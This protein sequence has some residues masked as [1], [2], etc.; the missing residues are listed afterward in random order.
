MD[1]TSV[2][3]TIKI[4]I[5][6]GV[7]LLSFS[8]I[9]LLAPYFSGADFGLFK[10]PVFSEPAKKRL[11]FIGPVAFLACLLCFA[12]ILPPYKGAALLPI[13]SPS[14]LPSPSPNDTSAPSPIASPTP[15]Q[16]PVSSPAP[17]ASALPTPRTVTLIIDGFTISKFPKSEGHWY[18]CLLADAGTAEGQFLDGP[19]GIPMT[20]TK[21]IRLRLPRR[22]EPQNVQIRM[23]VDQRQEAVCGDGY[24]HV[25]DKQQF[26][27]SRN[28]SKTFGEGELEWKVS[29]HVE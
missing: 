9:L 16:S 1:G 24:V 20:S 12:P 29:W 2:F 17:T 8:F 22:S 3:E 26:T 11:R 6:F 28:G 19:F 25:K 4:P 7:V 13:P 21:S 15:T 18:V 14:P 5:P 27:V 23:R 10:I